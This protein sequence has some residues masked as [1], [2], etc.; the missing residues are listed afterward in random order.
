MS[1]GIRPDATR[2]ALVTGICGAVGAA[3]LTACGSRGRPAPPPAASPAP[4]T[5]ASPAE[6]DSSQPSLVPKS[7]IPIDGG[8]VFPEYRLVV[9]RP[10]AEDLRA[11]TA[12]CTHE[13]C[14]LAAVVDGTIRCPCHGSRF[15]ITDGAVVQGPARRALTPRTIAIQGDS[16]VLNP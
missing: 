8:K 2:R 1:S 10:A 16:I 13:G 12:I 14:T 5:P 15:A 4:G 7:D 11:F 9:T 6:P 3:A